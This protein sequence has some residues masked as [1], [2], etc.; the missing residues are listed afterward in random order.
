MKS[1]VFFN[2]Y[3]LFLRLMCTNM[4]FTMSSLLYLIWNVSAKYVEINFVFLRLPWWLPF[5]PVF[6]MLTNQTCI[7]RKNYVGVSSAKK[8]SF[9]CSSWLNASFWANDLWLDLPLLYGLYHCFQCLVQFE[10]IKAWKQSQG[11]FQ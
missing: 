1:D 3:L 6:C 2:I 10:T 5:F 9:T 4:H 8:W 7:K 11:E